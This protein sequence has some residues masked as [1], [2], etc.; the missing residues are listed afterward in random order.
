MT[1][2]AEPTEMG[3]GHDQKM[4]R[5]ASID[6][7]SE[8][9]YSEFPK[10]ASDGDL[11]FCETLIGHMT[12]LDFRLLGIS[13]HYEKSDHRASHAQ[14]H[15]PPFRFHRDLVIQANASLQ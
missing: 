2:I 9:V 11:A 13:F 3:P 1:F 6:L 15:I 12:D 14:L 5:K 7:D 8:G 4:G 10:T